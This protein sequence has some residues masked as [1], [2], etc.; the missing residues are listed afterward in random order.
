MVAYNIHSIPMKGKDTF[1]YRHPLGSA[2]GISK[3]G[4]ADIAWLLTD[5]SH[6][7]PLALPVSSEG[8]KR[9]PLLMPSQQCLVTP[10]PFHQPIVIWHP[11]LNH[12]KCILL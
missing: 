12:G 4:K 3:N 8:H 9:I 6:P 11:Y 10:M 5:S 7:F 1:Q 2:L